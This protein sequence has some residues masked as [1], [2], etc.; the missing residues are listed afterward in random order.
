MNSRWK[1]DLGSF[2]RERAGKR[3]AVVGIG[4][5]LRG[6]DGAG[7]LLAQRLLARGV[8][9][10]FDGG[11]APENHAAGAA[12]MRPDTVLLVDAARFGGEAGEARLMGSGEICGGTLST[13][14]A[15]LALFA[16]YLAAQ[17]GCEVAFLGIQPGDTAVASAVSISV[18]TTLHELEELF[19]EFF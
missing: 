12:A 13:H 2:L 6:D 9:S 4:N 11:S 10:V 19:L 17:C 16:R 1:S 15:S 7:S 8:R 5:T 3:I 14:G 18:E